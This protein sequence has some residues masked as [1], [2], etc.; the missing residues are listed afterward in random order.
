[1]MLAV[2]VGASTLITHDWWNAV[3]PG[4][5]P[6]SNHACQLA[7]PCEIL[8]WFCER[9]PALWPYDHLCPFTCQEFLL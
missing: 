9:L 8:Y 4:S 1:M 3:T 2:A 5:A 6:T 7:S